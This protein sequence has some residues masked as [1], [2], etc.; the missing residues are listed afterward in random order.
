MTELAERY[1]RELAAR[2]FT[3][4]RAQL[5][6]LVPLESLRTQ[7]LAHSSASPWRMLSRWLPGPNTQASHACGIY[8][9]GGVGRGKTTL[10]DL[11]YDS[12]PFTERR[13]QHFHHF[14]RDVHTQLRRLSGKRAPLQA[15]AR[16]LA[17]CVRVL[18]LDELYVSDIADAMILGALFAALLRHDVRLVITSNVA[19]HELYR[20][21]LQRRH[22]LPTIALLERELEQCPLGDGLD[23]RLRQLKRAPIYLDSHAADC[24]ERLLQLFTELAGGRGEDGVA[25]HV[26][27][28]AV[29]AERC[30]GEVVWFEFAELCAGAR[31][32]NDYVELAQEF[33]TVLLSDVPVFDTPEQDDSAR[34]FIALVDEFYDQGTKLVL[35]AAAAPD[36]LYRA[37]SLKAQFLRTSSRLVE[38]QSVAY[39]ARSRRGGAPRGHA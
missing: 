33:A 2:G 1:A 31:S 39:L 29:R 10:M 38:M 13:R 3:S 25:V 36:A 30:R 6:A 4:D 24:R 21:G 19:P 23:Y 12:L 20:D 35:S 5:A 15:L 14:M 32:Q 26:L 8:L 9:Y 17:R 28:R 34:R 11:F 37:G 18:C 16:D 22:F 27:G 7:L